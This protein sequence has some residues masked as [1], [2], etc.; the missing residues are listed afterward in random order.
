[1][2]KLFAIFAIYGLVA[3][4]MPTLADTAVSSPF[5][6]ISSRQ[7]TPK[8]SDGSAIESQR[9]FNVTF[10]RPAKD[11]STV[12]VNN[13]SG[14]MVLSYSYPASVHQANQ[15]SFA[16]GTVT[17]LQP[18]TTYS[19]TITGKAVDT[20]ESVMARGEFATA[21]AQPITVELARIYQA[22]QNGSEETLDRDFAFSIKGMTD[23]SKAI[24]K[25]EVFNAVT[26]EKHPEDKYI[27]AH[28]VVTSLKPN[29]AYRY[30][31]TVTDPATGRTGRAEGTFATAGT[32]ST[33]LPSAQPPRVIT[34]PSSQVENE[35]SKL[36][37]R[38]AQLEYKI[39]DLENKV[40]ELEKKLATTTNNR[41]V[42][43][44]KGRILLQVE[45]N[46]EAWYVNPSTSKKYYLKDGES[47]YTALGAFGI[48]ILN[49]DLAKIPVGVESR[50]QLRDSDGDGLDDKLETALGTD[51]LKSDTD[52]D[53]HTDGD[54]VKGGYNS[55]GAGTQSLDR[56]FAERLKGQIVLQVEDRGQAWYVSP[57]DGKRYYMAD[58]ELAYQIMRYLSL[59]IT[60]TDLRQIPVGEFR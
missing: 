47:S 23:S 48:G 32:T 25:L 57:V 6:I 7:D 60:N 18:S 52:G 28:G 22:G 8:N 51:P 14:D 37:K 13:V 55:R 16:A 41:L 11:V 40:V 36:R 27:Q 5:S 31:Y 21:G 43:K 29:T 49:S 30:V 54:E 53:G 17:G 3:V 35:E 44:I 26:G 20:G 4:P 59:G 38:I 39:S 50:F 46:G 58:G 56:T 42:N 9:D 12:V 33:A 2:K 45:E 24:T 1:M 34:L 10:S 19:Y 15:V